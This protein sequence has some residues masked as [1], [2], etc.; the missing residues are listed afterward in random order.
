[1]TRNLTFD[2]PTFAQTTVG[3]DSL[4]NDLQRVHYTGSKS[5]YPPYNVIE[6]N[7][8]EWMISLAVAGFSM[9]DLDITLDKNMLIIKG[10]S[11]KEDADVKYLHKGI[12]RRN[13][14][15]Q[16]TLA[17]HIE[18]SNASMDSG[19]LSIRLVRNVPE[20]LQP[21]KIEIKNLNH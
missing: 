16:F 15:R 12:G 14:E 18:V 20:E 17:E 19:I 6:V 10:T 13:F 9:S 4:F 21:K 3:F 2:L 1:M 11:P 8:N 5:M 7:D